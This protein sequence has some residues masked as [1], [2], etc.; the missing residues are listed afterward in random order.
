MELFFEEF[1]EYVKNK[2]GEKSYLKTL[3]EETFLPLKEALEKITTED[4]LESL[5]GKVDAKNKLK[6]P[7][8]KLGRVI[9]ANNLSSKTPPPLP[10]QQTPSGQESGLTQSLDVKIVGIS[11][12][13]LTK[14]TENNLKT[15]SEKQEKQS[16]SG[17]GGSSSGGG[18][19]GMLLKGGIL[20][21]G[22][23]MMLKGLFSDGQWKGALKL[24]GNALMSFAGLKTAI[25]K[26][27][28]TIA[29]WGGELANVLSKSTVVQSIMKGTGLKA[30]FT[31]I[32][33]SGFFKLFKGLSK[34]A[35]M[36]I[37]FGI[38][39][40]I[41]F[42]FAYTRFKSGDPI[43]GFL[44]IASGIAAIVP[45]V[46]T[47]I[48]IGIDILSAI[49]DIT[50]GGPAGARE[51]DTKGD[52]NRLMSGLMT[53]IK[54]LT[55]GFGEWFQT[56][57]KDK[58]LNFISNAK[59]KLKTLPREIGSMLTDGIIN[60]LEWGAKKI[61]DISQWVEDQ[62]GV[63]N[64]IKN[65]S[66]G[67]KN[68]FL[69]TILPNVKEGLI[70][71]LPKIGEYFKTVLLDL[72]KFIFE[73]FFAGILTKLDERLNFGEALSSVTNFLKLKTTETIDR[74]KA[75][76]GGILDKVNPLNWKIFGG[77]GLEEQKIEL[78]SAEEKKQAERL[79]NQN[80]LLLQ[81]ESE[82]K[83][84]LS[85][86]NLKFLEKMSEV[87]STSATSEDIK[88]MTEI[89][90]DAITSGAA[91]GA[92]GSAVVAQATLSKNTGIPSPPPSLPKESP[93]AA[94]RERSANA[95]NRRRTR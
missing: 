63:L 69:N 46:G 93:I 42:G 60:A 59:E 72:P 28:I 67:A 34:K 31:K 23:T 15:E 49:R 2:Y 39:T 52:G 57:V 27:F 47:A 73:E 70:T 68:L 77:K 41:S 62:G 66:E 76:V 14:L 11:N 35:L 5:F 54:S 75:F 38:G 58:F 24:A 7:I 29:K 89:L 36:K 33:S 51:L 83:K 79:L 65:I 55:S 82:F 17:F 81:S 86:T 20:V 88:R 9:S 56:T 19:L 87:S 61:E 71:I 80:K 50:L 30:L 92:E 44:D 25:E 8:D 74:L 48:A 90:E 12:D 32:G 85:N 4:V 43:G 21:G 45:G 94:A 37:P 84:Q 18:L 10:I 40:L 95:L 22:V 6:E 3:M 91:L 1:E 64:I 16:L 53:H 78:N 26:T 13:I